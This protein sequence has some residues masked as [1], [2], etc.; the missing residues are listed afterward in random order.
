MP[1]SLRSGWG[2][3]VWNFPGHTGVLIEMSGRTDGEVL[4]SLRDRGRE[5]E[6]YYFSSSLNTYLQE[7]HSTLNILQMASVKNYVCQ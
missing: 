7:R 2:L 1:R 6:I 5:N 4:S 3:W